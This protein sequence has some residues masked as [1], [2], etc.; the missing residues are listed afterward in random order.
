MEIKI[1]NLLPQGTMK[2][3]EYKTNKPILITFI[4]NGKRQ[5]KVFNQ[6][7]YNQLNK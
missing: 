2:W 1:I 4:K 5:V 7:L 3:L 6:V